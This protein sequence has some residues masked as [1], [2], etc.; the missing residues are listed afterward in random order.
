MKR[1][2]MLLAVGL[3]GV[4][5]ASAVAIARGG[6]PIAHA[7]GA[8]N[9]QLHNTSLGK[10]LV[11]ASGFTLYEFT[12][13]T[14]NN[15]TCV[16]VS[17]CSEVWPALTTSGNPTA[18]SGVKSSLLSTIKLP[19][20]AKQ[21]TYAGHPLYTYAPASERAE[22][23]YVGGRNFDGTWYAVN[24]VGGDRQVELRTERRG[25]EQ[26]GKGLDETVELVGASSK[27]QLAHGPGRGREVPGRL[28][29][30]KAAEVFG[31]LGAHAENRLEHVADR[32]A[33]P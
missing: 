22:T 27:V 7:V 8:T 29:L 16:K 2:Y 4:V 15:D 13:D 11:N 26:S 14:R 28:E 17:G 6:V 32:Q 23:A 9:V 10:I 31:V 20:D 5:S 12:R 33:A 18:G 1:T 25:S 30:L 3:S 21:V 19:G 24:A